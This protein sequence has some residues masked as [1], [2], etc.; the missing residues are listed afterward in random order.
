[1]DNATKH[2]LKKPD[3]F[4]SMTEGGIDWASH[5]RQKAI[6]AA[7]VVVALILVI[8]GGYSWFE[9]RSNAAAT[10]FGEA[11]ETYNTPLVTPGQQVP[12]GMKTYTSASDRASAANKQFASV[13][14]QYGMTRPGKLAQ[15]FSGLTYMEEG[16]NGSAEDTL[17]KVA[18]SWDKDLSALGKMSLAQLYQQTGRDSQAADIYKELSNGKAITVPSGLAQLQ[19]ADM[20]TTEGKTADA[21]A[22]YAKLKDSDKDKKGNPGPAGSIAEQKLNPKA[23]G[24]QQ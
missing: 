17:K 8:V 15:Y 24:P 21:R 5:N 13:A 7:V 11:M 9:H 19:L 4:V 14:Q 12:P 3:Q 22:I 10:A 18:G 6:T 23:Q 16:Q 1:V 2:N 20:Y